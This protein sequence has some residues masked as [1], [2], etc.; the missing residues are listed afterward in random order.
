MSEVKFP[1]V[2]LAPLGVKVYVLV[3]VPPFTNEVVLALV[4]P[5]HKTFVDVTL[6][7]VSCVGCVIFTVV[8][9]LHPFA[10]LAIMV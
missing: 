10:S 4:P 7:H 9:I 8:E 5:K 6:V 1:V 2:L 3:P